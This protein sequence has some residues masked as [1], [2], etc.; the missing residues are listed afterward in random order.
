V[1]ELP[2]GNQFKLVKRLAFEGMG[3]NKPTDP[4]M[5]AWIEKAKD[6]VRS[7]IRR[8]PLID[9]T[10]AEQ[11]YRDRK[12]GYYPKGDLPGEESIAWSE[13]H[14]CCAPPA[15]SF[16]A[17]FYGVYDP[18]AKIYGY[19]GLAVNAV[20]LENASRKVT[21]V[22]FMQ[23]LYSAWTH[24]SRPAEAADPIWNQARWIYVALVVL[25]EEGKP[26][27][28]PCICEVFGVTAKGGYVGGI[29]LFPFHQGASDADY[30]E[31][32]NATV[33]SVTPL[34]EGLT[35]M[36]C[37]NVGLSPIPMPPKI[38][39]EAA[40][41]FGGKPGDYKYHILTVRP[42]GAKPG[43]QEEPLI[44]HDGGVARHSVRGGYANYAA[45][46]PMFG[47]YPGRFWRPWHMRGNKRFGVVDKDYRVDPPK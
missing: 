22:E 12:A 41:R 6:S 27:S 31:L 15:P 29:P 24:G 18:A 9:L 8:G 34:L 33:E 26:P 28:P 44:A 5:A 7:I 45:E 46:A 19:T 40:Y 21:G 13:Q 25:A 42:P 35:L 20:D 30:V 16:W 38:A 47:K 39:K 36:N 17:E 3:C 32:K 23:E 14:L 37:R 1:V 11:V 4:Y 2:Y 10:Y 43:E